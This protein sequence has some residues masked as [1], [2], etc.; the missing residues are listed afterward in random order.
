LSKI[1]DGKTIYTV[2]FKN[3]NKKGYLNENQ[4]KA[5]FSEEKQ[6]KVKHIKI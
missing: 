4:M 3:L 1:I 5:K 6:S 2:G